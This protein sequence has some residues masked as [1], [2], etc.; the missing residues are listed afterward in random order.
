MAVALLFI[1]FV[2]VGALILWTCYLR[3]KFRADTDDIQ[4]V[5]AAKEK[6]DNASS[7]TTHTVS[8]DSS[9]LSDDVCEDPLVQAKRRSHSDVE[10]LQELGRGAFGVVYL[11]KLSATGTHVVVKRLRQEKAKDP[12]AIRTFMAET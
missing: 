10:S 2:S 7:S 9:T 11:A 5:D 12:E 3:R 6:A 1:A 4:A 8:N